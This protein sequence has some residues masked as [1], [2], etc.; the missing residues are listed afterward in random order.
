MNKKMKSFVLIYA[1]I[2]IA[3]CVLF[4]VI[5]F[6]KSGTAWVEFAF[7]LIAI[8]TGAG[9]SWYAFKNEGLTSKIY[10]FPMFKVGFIYMIVQII[11]GCVIVIVGCFVAVPIWVAVVASIVILAVA[12]IGF[13]GT[14]NARDII[15]E[16]Q[17]QTQASVK[18]M[19][20][21]RLDMQYIVDICA[22]TELKKVLEKLADQFKF[23][24]P[25]TCDEL[26]DIEDNLKR[27]VKSLAAI[28]NSD[29]ELARKKIDEVS[30]LLAD[31]N[32]RCKESKS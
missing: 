22:D 2:F 1:I 21:F 15:I 13:I 25:V 19:K 20:M 18:Q 32:R 12:G 17:A 26:F 23:S 31:R 5:P 28:V 3:Y 6:P 8:C 4:L 29:K 30:I 24:D 14:D 27:E 16:Q 11:V 10:G 9:I 7:T